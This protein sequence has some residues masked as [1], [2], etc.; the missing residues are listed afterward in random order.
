MWAT[1]SSHR[2]HRWRAGAAVL[3]AAGLLALGLEA[4]GASAADG[5][6]PVEAA[7]AQLKSQ[8]IPYTTVNLDDSGRPAI[9]N[10]HQEQFR[11]LARGIVERLTHGAGPVETCW[12]ATHLRGAGL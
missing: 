4:P 11:V 7:A 3:A 5:D 2:T 12:T 8:G 10:Q 6:S 9:C 1:R